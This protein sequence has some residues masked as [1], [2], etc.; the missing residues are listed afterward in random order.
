MARTL[1][2]DAHD[3]TK[4]GAKHKYQNEKNKSRNY[5]YLHIYTWIHNK[6]Y[7]YIDNNSV[8]KKK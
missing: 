3:E 6:V 4:S 1:S 2:L 7:T 8:N 5:T